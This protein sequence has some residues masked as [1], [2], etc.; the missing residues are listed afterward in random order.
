[1]I[2]RLCNTICQVAS[3]ISL[4]T[5]ANSE[6][7]RCSEKYYVVLAVVIVAVAMARTSAIVAR[8][9]MFSLFGVALGY[10]SNGG[11]LGEISGDTHEDSS[12]R[13]HPKRAKLAIGVSKA[14][15]VLVA[16]LTFARA[17]HA[18]AGA[19]GVCFRLVAVAFFGVFLSTMFVHATDGAGE[20]ATG[21]WYGIPLGSRSIACD[22]VEEAMDAHAHAAADWKDPWEASRSDWRT[23]TTAKES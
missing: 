7:T 10:S 22:V 3:A 17:V 5:I 8:T 21:H 2:G 15:G 9:A 12:Q 20:G 23:G 11:S 16:G 18:R 6:W 4:S 1:M 14:V 19:G 13:R